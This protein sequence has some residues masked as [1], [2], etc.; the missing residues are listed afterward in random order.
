[1]VDFASLVVDPSPFQLVASMTLYNLHTV[2]ALLGVHL[3]YITSGGRLV[4]VVGMTE[5]ALF[6][7]LFLLFP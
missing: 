1:M 3:A 6:S 5:V 7:V 4:G 2:F